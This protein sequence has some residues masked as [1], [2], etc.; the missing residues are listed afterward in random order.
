MK[1][2][3]TL[4]ILIVSHFVFAQQ[5]SEQTENKNIHPEKLA[6]LK[7]KSQQEKLIQSTP[8]VSP[9]ALPAVQLCS[10]GNFEEFETVG[11]TSVLRNFEYTES[12]LINPIQCLNVDSPA[13][14]RI[15]DY[16]PNTFSVMATSVPSNYIDPYIGDIQAFDQFAVKLNYRESSTTAT[17]ME[18]HRF[19][20]DNEDFFKFNYKAVLQSVDGDAHVNE[21]PYFKVRIVLNSGQ[22]VSEMC[23]IGDPNNCIFTIAPYMESGSMILYTPNWQA[24]LLDI[25]SIPNNTPFTVQFI[26]TRCGLGAHFGYAY[27]DDICLLHSNE[28]LQGLVTLNPLNAICPTLPLNVCGTFSL[29][30]SGGIQATIASIQLTVRDENNNTVY[31]SSSPTTLDITNQQFCFSLAAANLPNITSGTYNVGVTINFGIAQTNCS[32]TT[33]NSVT[34]NDANAGWDIWFLNCTNCPLSV[35]PGNLSLCDGNDDGKEFFNL[36]LAQNQITSSPGVTFAF[37]TTLADATA[38]TNPIATPNA[39]ESYTATVFVRV[40]VDANCYKI[41]TLKLTVRN[42]FAYISGILNVCYGSTT[43]T[44]SPGVSYLWS[45]GATTSSIVVTAV[46]TYSVQVTD[47][48]GCI[49][50]AMVTITNS[51]TAPLPDLTIIQ[52]GCAATTGSITVTSPASLY[53]FDG[54]VTWGTSNTISGLLPGYYEVKIQ[55]VAGCTSYNSGVQISQFQAPFPNFTVDQPDFCGDT[56]TITITTVADFYSFD[57]GVTWVTNPTATGLPSGTY[58]IRTK[59]SNGCFSNYYAVE[60]DGEFLDPP[61]FD[62]I[63]PYCGNLGSI[64]ITTPATAYSFDGGQTWQTS[65]TLTNLVADSYIIKIKDAL[66]CTSPN[67]YVYLDNLETNYPDYIV[68]EPGCNKYG[69]I[70]IK[71]TGDLYS[72]DGGATWGTSN[73]RYPVNGGTSYQIKVMRLPSCYSLTS[74]A[75]VYNMFIPNPDAHDYATDYCDDL[76][77]GSEI[78]DLTQYQSNLITNAPNYSFSFFATLAA[79]QN[80]G[81]AINNPTTYTMSN[82]NNVVYVRVTDGNSCYSIVSITLNFLDSPYI[83]MQD[84]YTVCENSLTFIHAG[85]G[86]YSYLWS[87]GQTGNYILVNQPGNYWVT[88]GENHNGLVCTST[89]NFTVT[90]SEK[91][92]ITS[93]DTVDWT[94]EENVITVIVDGI[95]DYEYSLDGSNYQASNVFD[96]L[97]TGYYTIHIRDKKGC[98][99]VKG[100]ALLLHYSKFFTPNGDG[101]NDR[102]SINY[103]IYEEG[104]IIEIYDR[105]G[106]LIRQMKNGYAWDGT[107]NGALCPSDDYWFVVKRADGIIHKGHFTL[108]R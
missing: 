77:D 20:T 93:I 96:H 74:T 73:I 102:W 11:G 76:N 58:N 4:T 37:F 18:A 26:A 39:F 44:A 101:D 61:T 46:G 2:I 95:G 99:V 24:G 104:L 107:Y 45:T 38:N 29:P 13:N 6:F 36:T 10:N 67:V 40:T 43:L 84:D 25:S 27:I 5:T 86:Y 53:S 8:V 23:L 34:D 7:R 48:N 71:T 79:A 108:K 51:A 56:G 97:E 54:G 32:G 68:D 83:T 85:Y 91:A 78:I 103:S 89:K 12:D 90:E 42:P 33:F 1:K 30:S 75:Y 65:N 59:D 35:T 21:Q 17:L 94:L 64:T 9:N 41:T 55:T 57:D 105:Q 92:T 80:N 31:S 28:S 50:N 14:L 82:A 66:G 16:N 72:F 49:S 69:T 47:S 52:P 88:V 98:G 81:P 22:V 87:T 19:K 15:A 3:I 63:D 100:N 70:T 60:L 62:K 106:K